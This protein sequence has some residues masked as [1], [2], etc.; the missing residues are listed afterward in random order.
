MSSYVTVDL[1]ATSGRVVVGRLEHGRLHVAEVHRFRNEP[2]EAAQKQHWD[3]EELFAQTLVG[4]QR[5]A[6]QLD[7]VGGSLGVTAWGV[8]VGL[9]DNDNKLLAPIQH[10]RAAGPETAQPLLMRLGAEE[11]FTR[12]GV[13][14][15]PINTVFRIHDIVESAGPAARSEGVRALLVPDL[16]CALLTGVRTAERSIAST[17][18]LVS[19]RTGSWDTG[20]LDAVGVDSSILPPVVDNGVVVGRLHKELAVKIGA[21]DQ[22]PFVLVASHDTASAVAAISGRPR[23]AFVSSGTWSLVGVELPAPIVTNDALAAGF[24]NEAGL[25]TTTLFMRNLTGLW[26]LEQAIRQW[27]DHGERVTIETLLQA[28]ASVGP[29]EAAF[30]VS[31]PELVSSEDVLGTVRML[32]DDACTTPPATPGE[33]TRCIL[34]S[35]ALTYRRTISLCEQLTNQPVDE[36]HMIGGGSLNPLLRQLTAEAC[37]RP[38]RFGPVEATSL[39]SLATQAVALGNLAEKGEAQ[40]VLQ[41][42][43]YAGLLSGSDDQTVRRFWQ[44]LDAIVPTPRSTG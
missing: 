10:Y 14:P 35:L 40:A 27:H 2:L 32:C 23:T 7:G 21:R 34:Q 12:S 24:T 17:T 26:L 1:G 33:V 3:A 13:L 39:G 25:G 9:L 28:A 16:W 19:L 5:A 38:L 44:Q 30:D 43:S 42:S 20:L 36:V 6:T 8:D 29:L 18:G 4:L 41:R 31:S 15:Q 37:G 11:L 22:W